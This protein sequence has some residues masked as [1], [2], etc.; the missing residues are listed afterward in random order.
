MS[1]QTR[2]QQIRSNKI[3]EA[4]IIAIIIASALVVGVKTYAI[5]GPVVFTLKILDHVI[6]AIFMIEL[7]IRFLA[8]ENKWRFFRNGWNLFDT[9]IVT[10]SL[11]PLDNAD[12]A[13]VARLIRVFRVL[14]MISIIPELRMLLN[15]LLVAL[16]R[17][18]YVVALM[19]IIF[20]IYAAV[21]SLFFN[22]INEVLWGDIAIS[23]LTLFRVMT[24]ED[25]T[26]VMYETMAVYSWSWVFFVTFIF[27][28]AFAFLNMVIGIVVNV[29][30]EEHEKARQSDPDHVS[31]QELQSEIRE[32]KAM[33]KTLSEQRPG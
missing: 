8:E 22:E 30:E 6:T 14:R 23:M 19:F 10:V 3:F 27:L 1:W 33:V 21:G 25:W 13:L 20:Y 17:L 12:M 32:L 9:L 2:F 11:I 5:P 4:F 28:T 16:P 24:F 7:L 15:S 31:M 29:L 18:G 26:D